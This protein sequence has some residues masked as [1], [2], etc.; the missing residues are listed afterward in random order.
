M[1]FPSTP[2]PWTTDFT[3]PEYGKIEVYHVSVEADQIML[4]VNYNDYPRE[5]EESEVETELKNAYTLP[6]T[7][8]EIAETTNVTVSHVTAIEVVSKTGPIYMVG[9]YSITD[10]ERLYSLQTGSTRDPRQDRS[11]IDRFFDSF[12]LGI[13]NSEASSALN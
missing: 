1:E 6:D 3:S 2:E 12:E 8:A 13:E 5:M 7:G 11:V 4:A 9:R 10:T